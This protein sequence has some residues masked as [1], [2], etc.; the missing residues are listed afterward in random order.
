MIYSILEGSCIGIIAVMRCRV[1]CY[2]MR[3]FEK[4]A[5]EEKRRQIQ[6][7]LEFVVEEPERVML[8]SSV[9]TDKSVKK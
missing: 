2:D 9:K 7:K 5:E 3:R 1:M 6:Q 4:A 8:D